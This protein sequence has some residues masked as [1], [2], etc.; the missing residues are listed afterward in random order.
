MAKTAELSK[1]RKIYRIVS[2]IIT[3][4]VLIFLCSVAVFAIVQRSTD[5]SPHIFG[6]YIYTVLTDSMEPTITPGDV[7][8]S[9]KAVPSELKV[10]DIVTYKDVSTVLAGNNITHRIIGIYPQDNGKIYFLTQGDNAAGADNPIE[11]EMI[12]SVMIRKLE[13]VSAMLNFLKKPIGFICIIVIPLTILLV[14][15]IASYFRDRLKLEK[16]QIMLN[17]KENDKNGNDKNADLTK[18]G[19]GKDYTDEDISK[20]IEDLK[21]DKDKHE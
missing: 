8:L 15:V 21:K 11:D 5:K 16:D 7:I 1:G 19:Q 13:G 17:A 9:K 12:E 3:T 2:S 4:A 6:Y 18:N 10:G 14:L 20:L